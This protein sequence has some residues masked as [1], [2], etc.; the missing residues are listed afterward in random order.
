MCGVRKGSV[1]IFTP[2]MDIQLS[3][4]NRCEDYSFPMEKNFTGPA[5][6]YGAKISR[7]GGAGQA[8]GETSFETTCS[9]LEEI[10]EAMKPRGQK[11][12][13]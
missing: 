3:Q 12:Q 11:K 8:L 6:Q 7:I 4:H 13:H 1:F 10:C 5:L 2:P 9:M